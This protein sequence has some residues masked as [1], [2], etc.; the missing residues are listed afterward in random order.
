MLCIL[1]G[2]VGMYFWTLRAVTLIPASGMDVWEQPGFIVNN[3]SCGPES[4]CKPCRLPRWSCCR[5]GS[6][7]DV[8]SKSDTV[9]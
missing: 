2:A 4:C 6:R 5:F 1:L 7:G 3:G 8:E 9:L